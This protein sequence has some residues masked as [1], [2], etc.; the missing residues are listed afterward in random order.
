MF[1]MKNKKNGK[2]WQTFA[3]GG[4]TQRAATFERLQALKK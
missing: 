2:F 3:D 4:P 1:Y